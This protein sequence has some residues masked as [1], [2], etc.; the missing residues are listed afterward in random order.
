MIMLM[1]TLFA[2]VPL[3]EL[4]SYMKKRKTEY[5]KYLDFV[6]KNAISTI[7]RISV[8]KKIIE[9]ER[10]GTIIVSPM[11]VLV[12]ISSIVLPLLGLIVDAWEIF[13]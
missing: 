8:S 3:Q 9:V 4:F 2:L 5:L 1:L 7:E 12:V 11:N 13:Q 10:G 6:K